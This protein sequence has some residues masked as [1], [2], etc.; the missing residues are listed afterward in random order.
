[1]RTKLTALFSV[2]LFA[3]TFSFSTYAQ[4][5]LKQ[6]TGATQG[7]T[8]TA[9]VNTAQTAA[10][11]SDPVPTLVDYNNPDTFFD[12]GF[13]GAIYAGM[14]AIVAALGKFIPRL[15]TLSTSVKGGKLIS[16]GVIAFLAIAVLIGFKQGGLTEKFFET[17]TAQF[18][19][20]FAY[21][22]LLYSVYKLIIGFFKG[23]NKEQTPATS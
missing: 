16:S 4:D 7:P 21:S 6:R 5:S 8:Q 13:I 9:L 19:P 23:R 1:M 18:L 11:V 10:Q 3:L 22:G 15:R 20:N 14:L 12:Q 17:V 2:L